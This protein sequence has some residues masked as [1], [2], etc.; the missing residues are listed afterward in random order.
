LREELDVLKVSD[1][2][3]KRLAEAKLTGV[4]QSTDWGERVTL[5]LVWH[6]PQ[7]ATAP[8]QL[9][10]W[11]VDAEAPVNSD[12]DNMTDGNTPDSGNE[13]EGQSS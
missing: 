3:S 11:I 4:L 13:E 7:R 8:V 9:T 6:E 1:F 2:T 5:S 12:A 10:G